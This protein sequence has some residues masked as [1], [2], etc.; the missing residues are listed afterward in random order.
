M[1]QRYVFIIFSF[2]VFFESFKFSQGLL[3]TV[4]HLQKINEK[5]KFGPKQMQNLLL[6]LIIRKIMQLDSSCS[7]NHKITVV[8]DKCGTSDMAYDFRC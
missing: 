5:V 2:Y 6:I 8:I 4:F 1:V 3:T 7:L